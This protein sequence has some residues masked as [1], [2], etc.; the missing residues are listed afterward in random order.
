[1]Q[2]FARARPAAKALRQA[3]SYSSGSSQYAA[4]I[5]NLR[6][7]S[8]TKVIYQGFTG[9]QGTYV[10]PR[11]QHRALTSGATSNERYH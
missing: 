8:N 9:K 4:T 3:R 11:L 2:A 5:N 6:I 7:N 1:M 10:I